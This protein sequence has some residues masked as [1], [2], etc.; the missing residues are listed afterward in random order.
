ML[1]EKLLSL[2]QAIDAAHKYKMQFGAPFGW[3]N[4]PSG[5]AISPPADFEANR[6]GDP[7]N[8]AGSAGIS[9]WG[10]SI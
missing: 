6:R 8:T 5:Q 1:F 2:T 10:D 9:G 4:A 7:D 3:T